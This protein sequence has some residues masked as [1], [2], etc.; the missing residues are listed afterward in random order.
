M[1]RKEYLFV[2]GYNI[3][4]DWDNLKSISK[5][6]LENA[7]ECLIET[8]SEYKVITGVEVIIV[9]DAHLVKGSC[10]KSE[11]YKG[12]EVVF[13]KEHQTA[14][15]YIEKTLDKIGKIRRVRV[16]T[17]DFLEQQVILGRGGTRI[18]SRELKLEIDGLKNRVNRKN[19]S[20]NINNDINIGKLDDKNRD[21]LLK[22]KKMYLD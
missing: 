9:F 19:E 8:M 7:R 21:A 11:K 6:N 5:T 14:D 2:D 4:N 1:N 12:I 18:S 22:W 20:M 10:E 13:T 3:I 16:A 17:S 15:S